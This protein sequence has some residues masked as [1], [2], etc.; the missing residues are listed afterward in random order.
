MSP[1]ARF[2]DIQPAAVA[3]CRTAADVARALARGRPLA[4]RSGGH[5]FEGGS[6]TEG[7]LIDVSPMN[8]VAC[9]GEIAVVGAGVKLGALYDALDAFGRTVA[10]GC[11]PTVGISGL[12]LGGG[13]GILGRRFGLT[14]DQ[15]LGAEVVLAGG[16]VVWCDAEREPELFWGLRG[17]GG[18]RFGVV[19]R[20]ALRTVVAEPVTR[21]ELLWPAAAAGAVIDAWQQWAPDAPDD[22]AASLLVTAPADP[23]REP[24]V[25]VFGVGDPRALAARV[26]PREQSSAHAPY[27]E[28][29]RALAEPE[30]PPLAKPDPGLLF[31]K[32]AFFRDPLPSQRIAALLELLVA[33]RV[34][35]EARELDF[36]PWGGAY[37]R[38]GASD[39]A[40]P[41]RAERFLLKHETVVEPG[42]PRGDWLARS[43]ALAGGHGAYVNFPDPDLD[44]W[45]RAYHAA[46]LERL[47]RAQALYDPLGLFDA[48]AVATRQ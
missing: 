41:H 24:I 9:E 20:L 14:C 8:A 22:V 21:F 6:S 15:V 48:G 16:D 23:A 42:R 37:N 7:L 31:A 40:F 44:R 12:A 3:R 39:T 28:T 32:S 10:A 45:D 2:T 30:A 25:R 33:D 4:V 47:R 38:V 27:R 19:T 13:H 43:W 46:N 17:A 5:C 26:P 35:G 1:L 11:G 18:C 36:T 34:A 29:K